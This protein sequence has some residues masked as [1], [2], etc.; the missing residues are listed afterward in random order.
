MPDLVSDGA[1]FSCNFCTSKLK[2]KVTKSSTTGE[3]K[4]IGNQINCFFPPPG[5]NCTF[6][7]GA[8]PTPCPGIPPGSNISAGQSIVKVDQQTALGTG[9]KFICPK[10]Q[11][12]TVSKE[13]QTV[14]KHDEASPAMAFL[15]AGSVGVLE[16]PLPPQAKPFLEAG[17]LVVAG[18]ILVAS[19]IKSLTGSSSSSQ[20]SA[21]SSAAAPPPEDPDKK[22][23]D[24]KDHMDRKIERYKKNI[25]NQK[26]HITRRD[27]D[28]ARRELDGEVVKL[29]DSGQPFD[30]VKEVTDAQNGL[31]NTI[32]SIKKDLTGP[33]VNPAQKAAIGKSTLRIQQIVRLYRRLRT[34]KEF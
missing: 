24:S 20:T 21:S 28:A 30:H 15:I 29:K 32:Q 18:G 17:V 1:E 33:N 4:Q 2:L 9:A 19:A 6:P 34:L 23:K 22:P 16:A 10:G 8:P 25:D 14:A 13:G 5:G 31:R 3:E 12:V 26:E 27:L 7:P 11:P